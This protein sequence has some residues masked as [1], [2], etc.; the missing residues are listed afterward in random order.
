MKL[1]FFTFIA[2]LVFSA[3]V[4]VQPG[5]A[6]ECG[7]MGDDAQ[8]AA[9]ELEEAARELQLCAA[10]EE[11]AD[12]CSDEFQQVRTAYAVYEV[13]TADYEAYCN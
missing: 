1:Y 4:L 10:A 13:A 8:I 12:N 7:K 9:R 5:H 2:A 11:F 6:S 3:N